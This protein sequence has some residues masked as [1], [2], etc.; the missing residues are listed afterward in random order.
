MDIAKLHL[1]WGERRYKGK[2]Y[3]STAL[4]ERIGTTAKAEKTLS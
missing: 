3:R 4:P 2:T 1:H